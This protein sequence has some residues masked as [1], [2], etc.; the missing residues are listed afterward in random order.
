MDRSG[1]E[2]VI[3]SPA[4]RVP[5]KDKSTWAMWFRCY[6]DVLLVLFS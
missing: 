3:A 1:K 4:R 6:G 5:E 2:I